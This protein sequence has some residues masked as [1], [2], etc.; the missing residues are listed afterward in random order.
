V[1]WPLRRRETLHEV[2]PPRSEDLRLLRDVLDP[3][4]LYLRS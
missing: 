2:E 3:R 1:G 4:G